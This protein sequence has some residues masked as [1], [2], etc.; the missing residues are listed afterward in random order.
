MKT[1]IKSTDFKEVIAD[2]F[3]VLVD[4]NPAYPA[5]PAIG[6]KVDPVDGEP[7]IMP[8]EFKAALDLVTLIT[9]TLLHESPELFRHL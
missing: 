9:Q 2:G 1:L 6:L 3:E 5:K 8:I 4:S 7:F